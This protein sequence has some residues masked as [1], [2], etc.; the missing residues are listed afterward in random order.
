MSD[1]DTCDTCGGTTHVCGHC[2]GSGNAAIT[3]GDC[4][5][6]GGEGRVCDEDEGHRVND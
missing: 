3:F 5:I 6:C 4:G 1:H 2:D